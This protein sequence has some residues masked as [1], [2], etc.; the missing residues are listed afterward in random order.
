MACKPCVNP[1]NAATLNEVED[2]DRFTSY[3]QAVFPSSKT[4]SVKNIINI[5]ASIAF[6]NLNR[7][8]LVISNQVVHF[9]MQFCKSAT[10]CKYVVKNKNHKEN[11]EEINK[12]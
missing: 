5:S 10:S 11:I 9:L 2:H 7:L 4:N 12:C 3:M 8:K 6:V 1:Y